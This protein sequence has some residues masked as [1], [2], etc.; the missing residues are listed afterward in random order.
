LLAQ[1]LDDGFDWIADLHRRGALVDAWTLDPDRPEAVALA[2]RLA[3]L[4]VDRITSNNAPALAQVL[5]VA[6]VY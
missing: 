6:V 3:G 2:Q 5:D 4:G 1:A